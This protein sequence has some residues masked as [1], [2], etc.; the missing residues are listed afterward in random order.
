VNLKDQVVLVTG[1]S[2]GIGKASAKLLAEKGA[3]IIVHYNSNKKGAEETKQIIESVGGKCLLVQ[4]DVSNKEQ[5][6]Q[7]VQKSLQEFNRI[8][9]LVNNAGSLVKRSEFFDIDEDLWDK[10]FAI[11]AKS[12]FLVSH[13]VLKN[14]VSRKKGKIINI[15]SG[16]GA[17]GGSGGSIHYASTKGAVNALTI[18]LAKEFAPYGILVNGIAPGF[19]LN[20]FQEK[21]ASRERIDRIVSKVPLKRAGSNEDIAEM[22]TFLAS[23]SANYI[24]GEIFTISG[25]RYL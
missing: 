9:V 25:G 20:T 3:K 19:I 21:Y 14:M 15:S 16:A 5:V 8:D 17:H 12:V 13:A 22:V 24:T 6:D 23:D 18:S 4:A 2:S 11:N 1:A 10:A 7:M